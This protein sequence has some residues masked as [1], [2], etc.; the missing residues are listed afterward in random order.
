[1]IKHP[2]SAIL[3]RL[4]HKLCIASVGFISHRRITATLPAFLLLPC[5]SQEQHGTV[6]S[7]VTPPRSYPDAKE[8]EHHGHLFYTPWIFIYA[9]SLFT[10]YY[11]LCPCLSTICDFIN[12]FFLI[13]VRDMVTLKLHYLTVQAATQKLWICAFSQRFWCVT[14]HMVPDVSLSP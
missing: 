2:L 11:Y 1:M 13:K 6:F 7:S 10:C 3:Y 9:L 5:V 8:T 12:S 14:L 4:Q